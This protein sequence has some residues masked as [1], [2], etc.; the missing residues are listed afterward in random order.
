MYENLRSAG[1]TSQGS[2]VSGFIFIHRSVNNFEFPQ[3]IVA[4]SLFKSTWGLL[5]GNVDVIPSPSLKI[6]LKSIVE[7][8]YPFPGS[9]V[10]LLHPCNYLTLNIYPL[11][12]PRGTNEQTI[13][14]TKRKLYTQNDCCTL[15]TFAEDDRNAT[16]RRFFLVVLSC[17]RVCVQSKVYSRS[18]SSHR[19]LEVQKI[20]FQFPFRRLFFVS[21]SISKIICCF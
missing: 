14:P 21:V 12:Y 15:L 9:P 1:Y 7:W 5:K 3:I 11:L 4:C 6:P 2:L 8:N 17:S 16:T 20:P 13:L 18:K 19:N 10:V